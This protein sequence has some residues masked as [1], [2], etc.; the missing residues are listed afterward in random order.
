MSALE[1]KLGQWAALIEQRWRE[2]SDG[3]R[4]RLMALCCRECGA[5]AKRHAADRTPRCDCPSP[6]DTTL[7]WRCPRCQSLYGA[8]SDSQLAH[9][10]RGQQFC[11]ACTEQTR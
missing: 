5:I 7:S 4:L 9:R 1:I 2:L 10:D 3:E 11:I 6:F 8:G